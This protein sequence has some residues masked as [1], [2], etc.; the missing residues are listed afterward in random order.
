MPQ[1]QSG[2]YDIDAVAGTSKTVQPEIAL[3]PVIG[4]AGAAELDIEDNTYENLGIPVSSLPKHIQKKK[5]RDEAFKKEF[6][7]KYLNPNSNYY[8][9]Y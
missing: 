8:N 2:N 1:N 3:K 9:N 4:N 7:V 6:S 5:A